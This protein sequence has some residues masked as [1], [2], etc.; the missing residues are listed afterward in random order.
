M[1]DHPVK[2]VDGKADTALKGGKFIRLERRARPTGTDA[3][4]GVPGE[5][6]GPLQQVAY[7]PIGEIPAKYQGWRR[8]GVWE[9]RWFDKA[10][11]V[12][13]HRDF[14]PEEQQRMGVI[15]EVRFAFAKT[16]LGAVADVET[17]RFLDHVRAIASKPSPADVEAAGGTVIEKVSDGKT[18]GQ[19]FKST[20][21]VRVP[22]TK[23]PGPASRSTA[24]WPGSTF[25]ARSGTTSAAR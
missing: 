1:P 2:R 5:N 10:G 13:M 23:V 24:R 4:P 6:L 15:D 11:Q 9:A 7:V 12:G 16:I 21:W 19:T 8:D 25:P 17:A 18:V 3:L 22:D 20:E 14:T